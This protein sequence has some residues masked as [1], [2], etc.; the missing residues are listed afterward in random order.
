MVARN[1]GYRNRSRRTGGI[2]QSECDKKALS[3]KDQRADRNSFPQLQTPHGE[4]AFLGL[5]GLEAGA[6][7][8]SLSLG[9]SVGPGPGPLGARAGLG[10]F[11]GV[12]SVARL[13]LP[14]FSPAGPSACP[15]LVSRVAFRPADEP[16]AKLLGQ[17]GTALYPCA[18]RSVLQPFAGAPQWPDLSLWE[19]GP[20]LTF[21]Q[22]VPAS[23]QP[24]SWPPWPRPVLSWPVRGL[25]L[26][27]RAQLP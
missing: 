11:L 3:L 7:G 6:I 14:D 27:A 15:S 26:Q 1:A 20:W 25:S 5:G 19:L 13:P 4:P 24:P 21:W 9:L 2:T 12:G 8:P 17:P 18:R 16:Q 22:I 10:G 23:A